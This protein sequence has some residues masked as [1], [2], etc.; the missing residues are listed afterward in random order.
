MALAH[1]RRVFSP[2]WIKSSYHSEITGIFHL[3][4]VPENNDNRI[5]ISGMRYRKVLIVYTSNMRSS[6]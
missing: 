5:Q 3:Q 4:S 2:T 6:V 1:D